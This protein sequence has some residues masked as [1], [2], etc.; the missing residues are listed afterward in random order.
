MKVNLDETIID[1]YAEYGTHVAL[2]RAVPGLDGMKPSHRRILLALRDVAA[3]KLTGTIN[4]IGT[5]QVR[6]PFGN[7]EI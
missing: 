1:N 3:D 4:A 6:H 5:A 2:K 7:P